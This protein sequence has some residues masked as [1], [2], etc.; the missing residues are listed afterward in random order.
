MSFDLQPDL[1]DDVLSLRAL[2][3]QDHDALYAA[4]S[5]PDIW[6]VHPSQ[7]RWK[8]EV[9]RP[10]FDFLRKEGG[11]LVARQISDERVIG[12]SRFYESDDAPGDICIGYTFLVRDH[13]GGAMN[14]RMK[15]LMLSHAF[16]S[17]KA[18]WFHIGA[19]NLRS[20]KATL[21]LGADYIRETGGA[22]GAAVAP[23]KLYR[24]TKAAWDAANP[25]A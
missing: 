12:C 21:K 17:F 11:T 18:V 24:L 3:S 4:A 22:G 9:F 14:R 1:R 16:A 6:A 19:D 8:P 7:D 2:T 23:H 13:W 20:Q 5:D 15:S 25:D 10:Y